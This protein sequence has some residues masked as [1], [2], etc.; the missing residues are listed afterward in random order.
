MLNELDVA[1]NFLQSIS[2][3][4]AFIL[5]NVQRRGMS[6]LAHRSTVWSMVD[7]PTL[8]QSTPGNADFLDEMDI[9]SDGHYHGS[10][11]QLQ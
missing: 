3:S 9:R 5:K 4:F 11:D 8:R 1:L 7:M 2:M 6:L 10:R